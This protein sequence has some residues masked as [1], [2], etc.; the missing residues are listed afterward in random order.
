MTDKKKD[1]IIETKDKD[2]KEITNDEK[3][4]SKDEKNIGKLRNKNLK[5][6][7]TLRTEKRVRPSSQ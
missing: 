1:R 3:Y 5:D 2:G 7:K 6:G 4:I